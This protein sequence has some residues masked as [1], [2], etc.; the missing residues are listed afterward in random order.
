MKNQIPKLP[1]AVCLFAYLC[2][3][4][5]FTVFETIGSI[6]TG[7]D[8]GW[9]V[10]PNSLLYVGLGVVCV[11][12]LIILQIFLRL[13]NDRQ[14]LIGC[15]ALSV[16][17]FGLLLNPFGQYV[18]IVRFC[19]GCAFASASYSTSVAVLISIYSKVLENL[20]QVTKL[21]VGN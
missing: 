20:D 18:G 1:V 12:S 8:F 16:I 2:Y 10:L 21:K 13:L 14:V 17:G 19:L 4:T 11:F 6:Y 9:G 5:S 15:T 7:Q 3:T